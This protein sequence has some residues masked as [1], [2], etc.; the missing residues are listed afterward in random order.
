MTGD[1]YISRMQPR[2]PRIAWVLYACVLLLAFVAQL[3]GT[4]QTL[5]PAT[6]TARLW[7]AIVVTLVRVVILRSGWA[8]DTDWE[9]QQPALGTIAN[10]FYEPRRRDLLNGASVFGAVVLGLYWG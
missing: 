4:R 8:R 10:N 2:V 6:M 3:Q 9:R 7:I 1:R 5:L